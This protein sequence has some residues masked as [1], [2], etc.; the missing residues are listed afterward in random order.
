MHPG[1]P[2]HHIATIDSTSDELKRRADLGSPEQALRADHQ[3]GG[4][5]RL[6]RA[7]HSPPGNLHMSVL[8]RPGPIAR[9]GHWAL[10]AA[11]AVAE[12]LDAFLPDDARRRI[13]LKWPNDVM[14]DGAKLAGVLLETGGGDSPWLVIGIGANLVHAPDAGRPTACLADHVPAP[15]PAP[16]PALEPA[17]AATR[18]LARLDVWRARYDLDGFPPIHAA[19]LARGPAPGSPVAAGAGPCRVQGSFHGIRDDGALL[20]DHEGRTIAIV[21]GDV[22]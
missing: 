8:L 20:L 22:E 9:P 3:S 15:L 14:L 6:G 16:L 19:W 17:I 21:T 5:G 7:W 4:R 11:V 10:L 12:T 2:L 13:R 1:P 18:L